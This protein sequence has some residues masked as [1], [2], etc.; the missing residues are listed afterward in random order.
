M[1]AVLTAMRLTL[2][3]GLMAASKCRMQG[4]RRVT[5]AGA[6]L[7][8]SALEAEGVTIQGKLA[9]EIATGNG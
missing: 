9:P 1:Y 5:V 6:R 4:W 8:S 2:G 3:C 7:F